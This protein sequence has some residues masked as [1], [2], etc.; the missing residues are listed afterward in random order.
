[1]KSI[2]C[3]LI[4]AVSMFSAN[5]QEINC[6]MTKGTVFTDDYKNSEILA[7]GE[8]TKGGV[9]IVRLNDAY[10]LN[11]YRYTF[12]HYND[13]LVRTKSFEYKMHGI[14]RLLDV[15]VHNDSVSMVEFEYDKEQKAYICYNAS[16][17]VKDFKFNRKV[18]FK[19]NVKKDHTTMIGV[20]QRADD[21]YAKLIYN[22]DK[23]LF[24]IRIDVNSGDGKDDD[25]V[26]NVYVFNDKMQLLWQNSY[27]D[28]YDR[29]GYIISGFDITPDGSATYILGKAELK[30][31]ERK[32]NAA[33]YYYELTRVDKGGVKSK[34]FNMA[35]IFV[36]DLKVIAKKDGVACVGFY[37]ADDNIFR[38]G[39]AFYGFNPATLETSV[40]KITP[41]TQ[42]FKA[43]FGVEKEDEI[44]GLI[45]RSY[46]L[47]QNDDIILNGEVDFVTQFAK[48]KPVHHYSDIVV[49]KI[50]HAGD[51]LW[52]ENIDK[53]Q[54]VV[55]Y[56]IR[57]TLSYAIAPIGDDLYYF[58][59]G[60]LSDYQ[61]KKYL[62]WE[63]GKSADLYVAKINKNGKIELKKLI[64]KSENM[65]PIQ[66]TEGKL[67]PQSSPA[68]FLGSDGKK[69]QISRFRF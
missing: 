42:E 12:E 35:N 4:L 10:S 43:R 40:T 34:S 47:T 67:V 33:P 49:A 39:T 8:D 66:M 21:Y 15:S 53:S 38:K 25:E 57:K 31:K 19:L 23:T 24:A 27:K 68:Y 64:D 50:N 52:I 17:S 13:K 5:A 16:A 62:K 37:S 55:S 44:K 11:E 59:N 32:K 28:T 18:L 3:T 30:G 60:N 65:L 63:E 56:N 51:V 54:P 7:V 9:I 58:A 1:M 45:L 6:T 61:G 26:H 48:Q 29:K 20:G 41:F 14:D 22:Q 69:K 46:I 36:E 2:F